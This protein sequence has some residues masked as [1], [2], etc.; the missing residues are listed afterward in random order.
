MRGHGNLE[1]CEASVASYDHSAFDIDIHP[2]VT[3]GLLHP[4]ADNQVC[5][6]YLGIFKTA[7]E[8]SSSVPAEARLSGLQSA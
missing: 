8:L 4:D 2:D 3:S 5:V 6:K 1:V 7:K